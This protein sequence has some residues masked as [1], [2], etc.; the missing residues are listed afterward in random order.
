M[1]LLLSIIFDPLF[2]YIN[3]HIESINNDSLHGKGIVDVFDLE[4]VN[5][6][7]IDDPLYLKSSNGSSS[8]TNI[9]TAKHYY[10]SIYNMKNHMEVWIQFKLQSL[11]AVWESKLKSISFEKQQIRKKKYRKMFVLLCDFINKRRKY[12][13]N[14]MLPSD[15]EANT[16]CNP[17]D[18]QFLISKD[19]NFESIVNTA[20]LM[21]LHTVE[22]A[23]DVDQIFHQ[24][25]AI[26]G[27]AKAVP[28]RP[29]CKE[30]I[31]TDLLQVVHH[32]DHYEF[33]MR[34][35]NNFA[36]VDIEHSIFQKQNACNSESNVLIP[37]TS[38]KTGYQKPKLSL[39]IRKI[40]NLVVTLDSQTNNYDMSTSFF[41][42]AH[43]REMLN[44]H[45]IIDNSLPAAPS[46]FSKIR[47]VGNDNNESILKPN[48]ENME[49]M[50]A[51]PCNKR[52]VNTK[53]GY[54]RSIYS[55]PAPQNMHIVILV[56][57]TLIF[58]ISNY[59][60]TI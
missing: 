45:A 17:F 7:S 55:L 4:F 8:N 28:K 33:V 50:N 11:L 56:V 39:Q 16:F 48:I 19:S 18:D 23:G 36:I 5:V 30:S 34:E 29:S 14:L 59:K 54:L 24:H 21:P 13:L 12:I 47:Y 10:L 22:Y 2:L 53:D 15:N 26:V 37:E 49:L 46:N 43:D 25:D 57:G 27:N 44:H 9:A 42:H 35:E 40:L 20:T 52:W 1:L 31:D 38:S 32:Q 51:L 3:Q 58:S 60:Y 41:S 6:I